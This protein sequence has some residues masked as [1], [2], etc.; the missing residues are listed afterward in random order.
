MMKTGFKLKLIN[1]FAYSYILDFAVREKYLY[2]NK[3]N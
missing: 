2:F 1:S 3:V